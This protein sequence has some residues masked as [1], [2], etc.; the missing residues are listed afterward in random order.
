MGRVPAASQPALE[1]VNAAHII[2]VVLFIAIVNFMHFLSS[3]H[4]PCAT[5]ATQ[6]RNL[7]IEKKKMSTT[8]ST[9]LLKDG[10][11]EGLVHTW[12]RMRNYPTKTV[13]GN[14]AALRSDTKDW[15]YFTHNPSTETF[16]AL[17]KIILASPA[18]TLTVITDDAESYQELATRNGLTSQYEEALMTVQL[19]SANTQ[20]SSREGFVAEITHPEDYSIINVTKDGKSAASGQAGIQD[21]VA[22]FDRIVTQPEMRRQGL[23]TFVMNNLIADVA[24]RGANSGMLLASRDGEYLYERMGWSKNFD[25]L[26]F[27]ATSK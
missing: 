19:D 15:E 16:E 21:G 22:V 25:V 18:Q 27:K 11:L 1:P 26:I 20:A 12:A 17:S 6:I 10:F 9:H 4:T 24:N 14:P 7:K 8:N 23:G 3:K 13:H 5:K 2:G